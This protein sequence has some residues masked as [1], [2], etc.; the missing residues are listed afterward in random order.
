MAAIDRFIATTVT[1]S[2][3]VQSEASPIMASEGP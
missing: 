3:A 2:D 1:A